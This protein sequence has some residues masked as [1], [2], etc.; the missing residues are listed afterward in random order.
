MKRVKCMHC[1][2]TAVVE[3]DVE[4]ALCP[5]CR[6]EFRAR[7]WRHFAALMRPGDEPETRLH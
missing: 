5:S 7:S 6:A 4:F 3:D 2:R 1:P